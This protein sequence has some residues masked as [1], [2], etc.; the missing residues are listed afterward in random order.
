MKQLNITQQ[1]S[2]DENLSLNKYMKEI[3]KIKLLT[4]EEES[5]LT[6]KIKH[7]DKKALEALISSNLRF[8]VSVAKQYQ[9]QGL[10][11]VDLI[12]EGNIG[13]IRSVR[14]F[15]DTKGFKFVSYSVWWIRQS[16]MQAISECA[17]LVRV[18]INKITNILMV[19]KILIKLEQ[20]LQRDPSVEEIAEVLGMDVSFVQDAL[21]SSNTHISLDKPIS[22]DEACD[23]DMYDTFQNNEENPTDYNLQNQSLAIDIERTLNTLSK[24]ESSVLRYLFG[25]NGVTVHTID[26]TSKELNLSYERIRQ[27]KESTLVKLRSFDK[28]KLLLSY[29]Y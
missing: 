6:T 13:L 3:R 10:P 21:N 25:L 23:N 19:R 22:D 29:S 28:N 16:I 24:R 9:H 5:S 2:L 8:V 1:I 11:L 7:E 17:R 14:L 15:D 20:E 4:S 27:I 18:P 26:E 12:N